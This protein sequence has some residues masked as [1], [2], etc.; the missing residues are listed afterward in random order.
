M[1]LTDGHVWNLVTGNRG[2]GVTKADHT[3]ERA[4]Q[5]WSLRGVMG[6]GL[7]PNTPCSAGP[8]PSLTYLSTL[9]RKRWFLCITDNGSNPAEFVSGDFT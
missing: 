4:E 5:G 7:R 8:S 2:W 6:E 1:G 9:E 3:L